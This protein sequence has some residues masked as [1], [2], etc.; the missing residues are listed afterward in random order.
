[1]LATIEPKRGPIARILH[2]LNPF[3]PKFA[4]GEIKAFHGG[5]YPGQY[6]SHS[7]GG[8]WPVSLSAAGSG[9]FLN[10][11]ALRQQARVAMHESPQGRAIVER[12]VDAVANTGLNLE[13]TPQ[14]S[15]LGLSLD[16][17]ADWGR[18]VSGRFDLWAKDKKQHRPETMTFYQ[19]QWLYSFFKGRDNDIFVRLYYSPEKVLQNP[20]QFSFLDPDQIRGYGFTSS[21]G[22]FHH[23]HDGIVRDDRGREIAYLIYI[24]KP[25]GTF[26]TV[27]IKARGPKS[28]R[29]FM[30]HGWQSEY[31]GQGRGFTKLAPI[32]QELENFTD[33]SLA[34]IKQAINQADFVGWVT[35]SEDED[36][37]PVFN[38]NL[39]NFGAGPAAENF[40]SESTS[41]D[42][43]TSPIGGFEC[44]DIPESTFSVP[45]STF[46]QSLTKGSDIKL[47]EPKSPSTTYAEFQNAFLSSLSAASGTPLEVVHMKF[48]NNF[49][50]SRAT[51][52]LFQRIVEIEREDMVA[53]FLN[54]VYEMW[55]SGEIAAG[56]ISAPGWI[57]P[58][59]RK[60]W[61]KATWRG[62]PVPDIDPGKLAKAR[63]INLML[64]AT[65][66]EREAQQHS[67]T[68][69][70]DNIAMN[71][72]AYEPYKALP[73]AGGGEDSDSDDEKEEKS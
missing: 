27:D 7:A 60:A 26:D 14:A 41:E 47:A 13:S 55:M 43:G 22:F 19:A 8:K 4:H 58:R 51:L 37:I 23:H 24:K 66:I 52:L 16:Q 28:G 6:G 1:M 2:K 54:P 36:T 44:Y 42:L 69:A 18:D 56:R 20:L 34:H 30:L 38:K 73:F 62:T 25:D 70:D 10:H 3:S 5:G 49:S 29:I 71:N 68:G 35:P 50:A 17:A 31:A 59:L 64:G 61:L 48:A 39:T 53:D 57:D 15:I 11:Q 67:G 45:G 65:N 9:L 21:H 40:S 63:E 12:K 33:F 32:I 46:L 72:R